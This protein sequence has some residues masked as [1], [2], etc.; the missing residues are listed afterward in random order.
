MGVL[1]GA[2]CLGGHRCLVHPVREAMMERGKEVVWILTFSDG[3]L[4]FWTAGMGEDIAHLEHSLSV[5]LSIGACSGLGHRVP[6][7][8]W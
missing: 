3:Q 5:G 1:R 8:W 4:I 2:G 7:R 6:R